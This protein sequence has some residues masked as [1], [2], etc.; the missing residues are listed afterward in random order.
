VSPPDDRTAPKAAGE[1]RDAGCQLY[2]IGPPAQGPERAAAALE[3][4]LSEGGIAAFLLRAPLLQAPA[5]GHQLATALQ[6]VCAGRAAFL[7]QDDL[8]LALAL[9]ADG[10]HLDDPAKVREARARLGPDRILGASCGHSRHAAMLAGEDGA[11]YIAF[12]E[13]GRP[14]QPPL[15][16]LIAWWNELFVLPCLALGAFDRD[17]LSLVARADFIGVGDEVWRHPDG[18]AAGVRGMRDTIAGG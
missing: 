8:D 9:G 15:L 10:V 17:S 11:D 14:P 13:A 4:A 16:E 18:A 2:L 6:A 12:G 7:L 5:G 3:A 1:A